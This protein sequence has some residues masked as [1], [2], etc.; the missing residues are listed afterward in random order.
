MA[1]HQK[2]PRCNHPVPSNLLLY[3]GKKLNPK[4]MQPQM[5][6]PY[7]FQLEGIRYIHRKNG[8]VL[9][10]DEQGL[11]KTLMALLHAVR[12]PELRPVVVICPASLKYQWQNETMRHTGM[13][14]YVLDGTRPATLGMN[15]RGNIYVVNYDILIQRRMNKGKQPGEGWLGW[16][17]SL[18][19]QLVIIH[20]CHACSSLKAKRTK[21]VRELCK[22]VPSILA[23]SG[24]PLTNRPAE[25]WPI[26]NMLWPNK[27]KSWW[28]F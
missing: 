19:P 26:L 14:A 8:R 3:R 9:E 16:L 4:L 1:S 13:H 28:S 10:A 17:C 21:A 27:F 24:T 20:E 12:H 11:G 6:Q 2:F 15:T 22:G 25:L 7:T 23:M 5:T 18:K